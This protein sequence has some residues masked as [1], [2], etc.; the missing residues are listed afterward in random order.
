MIATRKLPV[1]TGT[2]WTAPQATRSIAWAIADAARNASYGARLV[3]SRLDLDGLKALDALWSA[4]GDSFDA[5][6]DTSASFV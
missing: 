2:A 6:F 5:R 4:R 3:D 1:W